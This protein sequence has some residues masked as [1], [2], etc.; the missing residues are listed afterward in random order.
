M[1]GV[2]GAAVAGIALAPAPR[3]I[4]GEVAATLK[5][6]APTGWDLMDASTKPS[7]SIGVMDVVGFVFYSVITAGVLPM[8]FF[9]MARQ[10]RRRLRMFLESGSSTQAVILSMQSET[11]AFAE[12]MTRVS[13]EFEGDGQL[14]RD[15]DLIMPVISHRW[16]VGDRIQ[17]LYMAE[18]DYDSIII[19]T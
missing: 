18:R 8:V 14:R 3:T 19:S 16:A 7:D 11:I 10:R 12:K 5:R 13:Y 17:V 15:S 1:P 6:I 9:G 2:G 4:E